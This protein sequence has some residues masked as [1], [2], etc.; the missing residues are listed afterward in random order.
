MASVDLPVT[1]SRTD[2]CK[3]S[4]MIAMAT[5]TS[6][7]RMTRDDVMALMNLMTVLLPVATGFEDDNE[8]ETEDN[9]M[10]ITQ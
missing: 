5:G 6:R 9:E 4:I 10:Y 2:N 1:D 7:T 8:A 3:I